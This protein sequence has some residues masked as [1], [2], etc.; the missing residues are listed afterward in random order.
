MSNQS[1]FLTGTLSALSLTHIDFATGK[2]LS[3]AD[4]LADEDF[5]FDPVSF[6]VEAN[7]AEFSAKHFRKDL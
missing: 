1:A 7:E 5:V 2:D 6:V 3:V 4:V